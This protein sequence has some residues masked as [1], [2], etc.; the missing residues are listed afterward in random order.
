VHPGLRAAIDRLDRS[1]AAERALLLV[2]G[3]EAPSPAGLEESSGAD[4]RRAFAVVLDDLANALRA[5]GDLINAAYG[6]NV[7][8]VDELLT[9]TLD[10]VRETRAVLTELILLDV[11]PRQQRDL[12]MLQSSVLAAVDQ[13]LQQLDLEQSERSSEAWL[14]RP[15]FLSLPI[16]GR[17]SSGS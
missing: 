14:D 5:F 1:L 3:R 4:L 15:R 8:D 7:E 17:A 6:R 12:W 10:L 9:R 16:G 11:D 13:V 2:V